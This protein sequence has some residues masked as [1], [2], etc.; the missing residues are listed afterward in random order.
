MRCGLQNYFAMRLWL[1][2][3]CTTR[4]AMSLMGG[5]NYWFLNLIVDISMQVGGNARLHILGLIWGNILCLLIVSVP[6]M[7][8]CGHARVKILLLKWW[9]VLV[10]LVKKNASSFNLWPSFGF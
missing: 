8:S 10:K 5:K 7:R 1:G 4:F 2:V 6:R 9:L 3:R